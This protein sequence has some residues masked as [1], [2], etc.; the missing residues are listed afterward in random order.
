MKN[1]IVVASLALLVLAL[2]GLC[3]YLGWAY[4]WLSD[5]CA[6]I[7]R[8]YTQEALRDGEVLRRLAELVPKDATNA[9]ELIREEIALREK[10]M[11][12]GPTG[13]GYHE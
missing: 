3:G 6:A 9:Q 2:S 11:S 1:K 13:D 10:R 12:V 8:Q 4:L 5:R 7:H